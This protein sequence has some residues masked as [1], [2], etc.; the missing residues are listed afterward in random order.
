ME[1][2]HLTFFDGK[3]TNMGEEGGGEEGIMHTLIYLLSFK[4][5]QND[6]FKR[7]LHLMSLC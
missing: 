5:Q 7:K 1:M 4:I 3:I 2:S 6:S